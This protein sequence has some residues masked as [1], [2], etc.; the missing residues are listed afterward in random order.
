MSDEPQAQDQQAAPEQTE[1]RFPE[2]PR[3]LK[4]LLHQEVSIRSIRDLLNYEII[5]TKRNASPEEHL[6]AI[7]SQEDSELLAESMGKLMKERGLLNDEQLEVAK[8]HQ[9]RTGQPF[10]RA[11]LQTEIAVPQQID[12]LL[13]MRI[14]LPIGNMPNDG[15]T[16]WLIENEV[17]TKRQLAEAWDEAKQEKVDFLTFLREKEVADDRQLAQALAYDADLPYEEVPDDTTLPPEVLQA[18]PTT[19]LLKRKAIPLRIDGDALFVAFADALDMVELE[20]M[21]VILDHRISPVIVPK[22]QLLR[23]IESTLESS[24]GVLDDSSSDTSAVRMLDVILR[25]LVRC[26]G[27]DLHF[28][29]Q[30]ST[31]RVRYRV[32]GRLHDMMTLDHPTAR[33]VTTRLLNLAAMDVVNKRQP[34]D[35]YLVYKVEGKDCDV[36]IATVPT[37]Y[38]EKIAL[39]RIQSEMA[40]CTLQQLGMSSKQRIAMDKILS[41]PSGLIL[42]T[43]PVGAGKTT[44][45]YSCLSCLNYLENNI[46]TIEDPVEY[47]LPGGAQIEVNERQGLT[48]AAGLRAILRQDPDVILVGEIRDEETAHVAIRAAM[49]GQLVF[50]TL[51]ANSAATAVTSIL[52]LNV[53]PYLV[54]QAIT[55]ILFQELVRKVCPHCKQHVTPTKF[56]RDALS[57]SAEDSRTLVRGRGCKHCLQTG[58]LGRIGVFEI[59][60]TDDAFRD[61]IIHRPTAKEL[62][63]AAKASGLLPLDAHA[64][65]LVQEGVTSFDEMQRIL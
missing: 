64:A 61:A 37:Q 55:G 59:L 63:L 27:T 17:A 51:H 23:L 41:S 9:K 13:H 57:M 30:H 58:Y 32:D 4:F 20:R 31:T 18:V 45:L 33:R 16:T 21:E 12:E 25:G 42:V 35:G 6:D 19:L 24:S 38:G 53:A 22:Q 14:P 40:H 3:T 47:T 46:M 10:L 49:T 52:N 7:T 43:G 36:R 1:K 50:A 60:Q 28:E 56:M 5:S 29:P 48:F 11:L 2:S 62:R 44:T 34:K 15:F 54:S 39:R 8:E 65:Q 26:N